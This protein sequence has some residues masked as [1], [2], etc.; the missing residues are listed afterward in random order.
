MNFSIIRFIYYIFS[1][2]RV[3]RASVFKN[4]SLGIYKCLSLV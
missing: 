4:S 2:L 1:S 3:L